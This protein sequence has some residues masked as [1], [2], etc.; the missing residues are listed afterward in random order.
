MGPGSFRQALAAFAALLETFLPPFL[1]R[2]MAG[3]CFF[4]AIPGVPNGGGN[5]CGGVRG[6][7]KG[8][9]NIWEAAGRA[10]NARGNVRRAFLHVEN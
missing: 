8:G 3:R 9:G 1:M 2:R 5:L 6:V 7:E 10:P 4:P